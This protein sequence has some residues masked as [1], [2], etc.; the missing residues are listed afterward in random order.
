MSLTLTCCGGDDDDNYS[1]SGTWGGNTNGNSANNNSNGGSSNTPQNSLIYKYDNANCR[2]TISGSGAMAD[3]SPGK[4]PWY[5]YDIKELVIEEGCTY[6]GNCAFKNNE[7]TSHLFTKQLTKVKLPRSLQGIGLSAFADT[8]LE[9]IVMYDNVK[10]IGPFAFSG[11]YKLKSVSL[12]NGLESIGTGAFEGCHVNKTYFTVPANVKYIGEGAFKGWN[13]EY[14]TLNDKLETVGNIAFDNKKLKGTITI[15][16]SVKEIGV[17][18]FS[19]SFNKV[20]IGNGIKKICSAF[21]SSASSGSFY[22][23][24]ANPTTI[25][26]VNSEIMPMYSY[27]TAHT[28]QKWWNLYVP[29]GSKSA[30]A[31]ASVWRTFQSITESS[32][33][34]AD[35]GS[36]SSSTTYE[37][38]DVSYHTN[39]SYQTKLKVVFKIWNNDKAKV[40]SAKVYYGTSSNPTSSVSASVAGVLITAN[41]SNLKK[42]TTYYVKCQATG[43]GGTTT[44]ETVKLMTDY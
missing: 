33:P 23:N 39:T 27:T 1:G 18:A 36:S 16:N 43:K 42:G 19:G 13:I 44:T 25:Q 30:Y 7:P 24:V 8:P 31:N 34:T 4:Q 17:N 15:P 3:Y 41:I 12:S 9:E 22:I 37:K 14:L 28:G 26:I 2:L 35:G 10:T 20:I 38:P 6:I 11:C 40:S 21:Q 29:I 5:G 32:M